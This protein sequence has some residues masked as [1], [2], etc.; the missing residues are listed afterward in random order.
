LKAFVVTGPGQGGVADVAPP[1]AGPGQVVVDV[2]RVGVCGTDVELFTGTMAYLH[3][4]HATYPIRLGH[5][6]CGTVAGVG[7]DVDP[8]WVGRRVTGDT[9]LGC[10]RC[11]RCRAGLHHVCEF[12]FEIGIRGGWPGALA[13]QLAVPATALHPLPASVGLVAGAL[14][15]PGGNALRAVRAAGLAVGSRLAIWGAGTI[16]LLSAL[17]ALALGAEVHV[18]GRSERSLRLARDLGVHGAWTGES[19][20]RQPYLAVIDATDSPDVPGAALELVEPAGRV[21]YIGLAGEPSPID[22][23]S[24]VLKDVTA[25][26][27][28]SASPGLAG[29][30]EHYADGRVDPSPLVAATV[31][32]ERVA[33]VLA[34]WRPPDAGPGPKVH[35]DPGA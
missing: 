5:E 9:M 4:G 17:F 14:V 20:P 21:V 10:G 6:W 34:G 23:R 1:V 27:L 24:L 22:T 3:Q 12:R 7:P 19:L 31:G 13:E 18:I 26:G 15:E 30:I 16:G 2:E 25:V 8:G 11:H 32:L 35:V 33:D 28:L 29:A